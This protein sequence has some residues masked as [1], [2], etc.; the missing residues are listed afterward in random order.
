[1]SAVSDVVAFAAG[2][3]I[4]AMVL[5]AVPPVESVIAVRLVVTAEPVRVDVHSG[6]LFS[7]PRIPAA[8]TR[9]C[10]LTERGRAIYMF[11]FLYLADG[12]AQVTDYVTH[13]RE[14]GFSAIAINGPKISQSSVWVI[15][16]IQDVPPGELATIV[17]SVELHS[18]TNAQGLGDQAREHFRNKDNGIFVRGSEVVGI[19]FILKSLGFIAS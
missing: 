6:P 19:K 16:A 1:M 8:R 4:A 14:D 17:L 2:A 15:Y 5:A 18:T 7:T 3:V 12:V 10:V 9:S 13:V 11:S